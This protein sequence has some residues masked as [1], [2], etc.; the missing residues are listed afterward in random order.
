MPKQPNIILI[1]TDQQRYDTI[2]PWKPSFLRTP[3]IDHLIRDGVNFTSAYADCPIC[4]ASRTT[5]MTGKY[6]RTH[7]LPNNR[8]TSSA[9][10][11]ENTLPTLLRQAGYQTAAIGKMHFGPERVRHG[12]DEMLL[13]ADYYRWMMKSGNPLQPMHHGLGQNELYPGMATVPEALTLTSWTAEQCVEYIKER[14]DPS[15]PFFLW[16]SFSKPHPPLDPPEPYYSMYR[17]SPIPDPVFGDWCTDDRIPEPM[18]RHR[19][20]WSED[21]IPPEI[22][23]EARSAYYGLITQI[24]YNIGRVFAALQDIGNEMFN[25]TMF[26]FTSDHGE[27]LGDHRMGCKVYFNEPSAHIPFVLRMP[28]SW[29]GRSFGEASSHVTSL[30]DVLPTLVS[31]AGGAAP[32]GIDGKDLT[33]V[34]NG[35]EKPREY[36]PALANGSH[37]KIVGDVYLGITDGRWKYQ[38]FPEGP[39]ELFF[40]LAND[41]KELHDLSTDVGAAEAKKRMRGMLIMDEKKRG[42][43]YLSGDDL[44][45]FPKRGDTEKE[46]RATPWPGYHTEHYHIDVRH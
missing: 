16:S 41:P 12:F 27:F 28:K 18:K 14:R 42:G 35:K 34:L 31:A 13:P 2:S 29:A 3:H 17:N 9:F 25:E 37:P 20:Q 33:A 5:I 19:Q 39:S 45:S 30:A 11:R 26:L 36:L 46:R 22:I 10:G 24:D 8:E 32:S 15:L 4:V 38:Y 43:T 21:V 1:T 7:G 6:A 44:V 40:D 23:R